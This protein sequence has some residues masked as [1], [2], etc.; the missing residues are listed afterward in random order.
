MIGSIEFSGLRRIPATTLRAKL[1]S[2]VGDAVDPAK[3]AREVRALEATG[4]FE[5]VS[6]ELEEMPV[7]L[8]RAQPMG[9]KTGEIA[10]FQRAAVMR[11]TFAVEERPFLAKVE[12]RGGRL[13][14]RERIREVLAAKGVALKLAGPC[15]RTDLWRA[16]RALEGAL[17]ELGHPRAKVRVRLTEVP[18]AA[19]RATFAIDEGPRVEAERVTFA[20]NGAFAEKALQKQL[21]NVA[22]GALFASWRGKT[23][24]TRE[25]MER[26]LERVRQF[27]RNH[28]YAEAQTGEAQVKFVERRTRRWWPWPGKTTKQVIYVR[29]PVQEGAAYRLE[30]ADVEGLS[31]A[32][33][34]RLAPVLGQLKATGAYSEEK[35]LRT[36]EELARLEVAERK[37]KGEP[38]ADV[39]ATSQM[40]REAGTIRVQFRVRQAVQF[41]V[42]R[43]EFTGHRRFSDRYY[44]RRIL[45]KEG[46]AF[47]AEKLERGLEQ[48]A[49]SGFVRPPTRDDVRVKF[50]EVYRTADVTIRVEEIGRQRISLTGGGS[51]LGNAL[52]I[53]YNVFDLLGVEELLTAHIEGGPESLNMLLGLAKESV[54]GTRASLGVSVFRNVVQPR[55]WGR[56]RLFRSRTSGLSAT[57]NTPLTAQDTLGVNY[58]LSRNATRV[59]LQFPVLLPTG[60]IRDVRSSSTRNAVNL[61]WT[62]DSGAR[63]VDASAGVAGGWLGGSEKSVRTSL[64]TACLVADPL[65]GRRNSWAFRGHW[66]GASSF[67]GG[68]LP[69]AVRSF[70]G[71][72]LIR[73]FRRGELGPYVLTNRE[74]PGGATVFGTEAAGANAAVAMN[75]EYRVPLESHTEIAAF[76]DAGAAWLVPRW[77]GDNRPTVVRGTN[78]V[79]RGSA[80]LEA[81]V[82]LPVINQTVR[83]HYAVNPWRLA[84]AILLPDGTKFRATDRRGAFGWALGTLF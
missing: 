37:R 78:G 83:F 84:R 24:Y 82:R 25:R 3:I 14:T 72:D 8:A 28:G 13:M 76:L 1:G 22:P 4:W 58:E 7:L 40:D 20:G 29:V 56:G 63:R 11:L 81:R 71:E 43:I 41:M 47:D 61:N 62:R 74:Q 12:F 51:G 67:G 36:K 73:G 44:R 50:D 65:S 77:L 49:R 38:K 79:A 42:R 69:L 59:P 48:L 32:V 30:G 9:E 19:V 46:E 34:E 35:V 60:E 54:F 33:Q 27:Y 53:A 31:A 23:I 10:V 15:K 6:V 52:G 17:E 80:G 5:S 45:L 68:V 66:S 26:D 75:G 16:A 70:G 64:T 18:T 39:E 2:K 21:K 55:I 57:W